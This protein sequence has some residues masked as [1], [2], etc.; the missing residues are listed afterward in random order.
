MEQRIGPARAVQFRPPF[1][2]ETARCVEV[3]RPRV[4]LVHVDGELAARRSRMLD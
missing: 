2:N 4:L 1:D 3:D